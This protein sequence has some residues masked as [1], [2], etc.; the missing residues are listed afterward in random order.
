MEQVEL[1]EVDDGILDGAL[2]SDSLLSL[3]FYLISMFA[4]YLLRLFT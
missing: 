4:V 3:F 2:D 1:E